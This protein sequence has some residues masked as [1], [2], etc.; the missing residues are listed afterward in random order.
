MSSKN[1]WVLRMGEW[2]LM[3]WRAFSVRGISVMGHLC[4]F[5]CLWPQFCCVIKSCTSD[6]DIIEFRGEFLGASVF[7]CVCVAAV[8]YLK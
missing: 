4:S 7:V 3:G 8:A 6:A 2:E 5:S 1:A